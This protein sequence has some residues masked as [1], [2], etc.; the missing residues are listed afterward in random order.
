[1]VYAVVIGVTLAMLAFV[2]YKLIF[3]PKVD[4]TNEQI[5]RQKEALDAQAKRAQ[6]AI[7]SFDE[8]R[9]NFIRKYGKPD[10]GGTTGDDRSS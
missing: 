6:E 8:G 4:I 2:V 1:M 9:S 5:G 7:K 3:K 10:G